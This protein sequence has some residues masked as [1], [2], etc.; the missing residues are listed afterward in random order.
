MGLDITA[1]SNLRVVTAEEH[2]AKDEDWCEED[3][4]IGA[5]A[6]DSFPRSFRGLDG[7]GEAFG[8]SLRGGLCYALTEQ[9]E[10]HGFRAGSYSGYNQWRADLA[11]FVGK[12]IGDYWGTQDDLDD[13]PF[14]EL[15]NFAD[16]EGC[17]G[18]EAARDL[19]ADFQEHEVRYRA[20]HDEYFST[21]YDDWTK[22]CALAAQS[23]LISFH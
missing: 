5:Y 12:E 20:T 14:Y 13:L 17:I 4:H 2:D 1:Y 11:E 9:T 21:K 19:L 22:A 7:W 3:D 16:N 10:T 15:I 18:P 8:S 23:G 6:Y